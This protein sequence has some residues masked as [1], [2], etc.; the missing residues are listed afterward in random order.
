MSWGEEGERRGVLSGY[1]LALGLSLARANPTFSS[2]Q[3]Q[4]SND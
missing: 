2:Q 1:V 3:K 4:Q